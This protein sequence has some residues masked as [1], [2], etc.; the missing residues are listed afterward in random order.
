VIVAA[1]GIYRGKV[2]ESKTEEGTPLYR[3][4]EWQKERRDKAKEE[5]QKNWYQNRSSDGI[6][7]LAPLILDPT[8]GG[9]M[10]K[11]M[12][13]VVALFKMAHKIGIKIMERGGRK[14]A[15]DIRSD[16]LG[17][18]LCNKENCTICRVPGSKGGCMG[19]GIGYRQIC[20]ECP[21][22]KADQTKAAIYEGESG[23]SAYQR[24]LRH[25]DDL[26]KHKELSP[27]WKH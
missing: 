22:S 21:Y 17:T 3:S 5:K 12:E 11:E 13:R 9:T 10:R 8:E 23:Q 20:Q 19:R 25:T 14:S 7:N 2:E 4:R 27:L 1:I 18:K 26:R 15:A 6:R 16:P 24:G